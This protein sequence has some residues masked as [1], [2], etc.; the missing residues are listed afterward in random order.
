MLHCD[1]M[2]RDQVGVFCRPGGECNGAVVQYDTWSRLER[3]AERKLCVVAVDGKNTNKL[4][5]DKY[6]QHIIT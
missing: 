4:D 6:H 1:P 5:V 3:I 2:N